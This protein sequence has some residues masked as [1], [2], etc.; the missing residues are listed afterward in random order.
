M[1]YKLFRFDPSDKFIQT[2]RK[3]EILRI[4]KMISLEKI[5]MTNAL[6]KIYG[7]IHKNS[8]KSKN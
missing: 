5:T 3:K 8:K 4:Y 6:Y 7:Y 2:F 1:Y